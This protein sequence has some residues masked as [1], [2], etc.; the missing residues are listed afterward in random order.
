MAACP[1]SQGAVLP[2][3]H[4]NILFAHNNFPGQF[5]RLAVALA[6]SPANKVVFL[7][8]YRR[9]DVSVPGV[10]WVQVPL[11][12]E[13]QHPSSARR[14]YLNLLARGE[15]FA[16]AMLQ[17]ARQGFKPD[18]IYGHVGFGCC[19]YAPD[20]FPQ[21]MQMGY[22]EWY[23]TNQADTRFFAG[24]KPVSLTTKAEN[25]QCNMCTL[26]A[27]KECTVGIC[28]THWQFAQ[29]PP[30][31]RHKLHV[32]HD[33]VDTQFFSPIRREG[34]GLRLKALD[35]STAGEIV[36]YATRGLEPYRGFHTFYRSLPS[37]LEARPDAHVVIMAD[38][39]SAYGG[40]R[41]DGKTWREVLREEVQLDE[42]RVHFL[43]F[44][45][46]DQYRALLR[47]SD[48]HVYL[49]APFVLSWSLL[50]AMSCGCLVVGSDT[51]PVREVL[52]HGV[53]GF[54]SDF[55]NHE[56]LARRIISC[57]ERKAEL[58][59]VRQ[60]ARRHILANYDLR[61]LLPRH[62][63]LMQAGLHLRRAQG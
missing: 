13:E 22:F 3:G 48:V 41:K 25:R 59:P 39:R 45:P 29:H 20:I 46:Y 34:K 31:F 8:Q 14:K 47:A 51:E 32:L 16:D 62:V 9:S 35:L 30:E 42:S 2:G 37:V 63:E 12:A 61:K 15:R 6:A 19:I 33:G 56:A 18:V 36:T 54:L 21:A 28:P 49:T 26:S 5:H 60:Q 4:M 24:N 1:Y 58:A 7:S 52:R 53:N 57:L 43:P 27:L 38:D 55:W 40:P 44:Q 23:Y 50:E 17:L 11:A 10:E